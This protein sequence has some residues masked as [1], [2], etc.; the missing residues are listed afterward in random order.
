LTNYLENDD[1]V[2]STISRK[3]AVLPGDATRVLRACRSFATIDDHAA[4]L[5]VTAV[6]GTNNQIED[7]KGLLTGLVNMGLLVSRSCLTSKLKS[8]EMT[9]PP[10]IGALGIPTRDRTRVLGKALTEYIEEVRRWGRR[11]RFVIS[12]GSECSTTRNR[13]RM[14]LRALRKRYGVEIFY[15]GL[16]E[17]VRFAERLSRGKGLP[18]DVLAFAFLNTENCGACYGACRNTLLISKVGSLFMQV[19]DDTTPHVASPPQGRPNVA[20]S[21]QFDPTE[22]WFFH[23]MEQALGSA[24]FVDCNLLELHE[25]LLG[26]KVRDYL[27]SL[28]PGTELTLDHLSSSFVRKLGQA[29]GGIRVTTLGVLGDSGIGRAGAYLS[30]DGSSRERLTESEAKYRGVLCSRKVLRSATQITIGECTSCMGG[31]LGLDARTLLPPFPPAARA[32]EAV[33][34]TLLRMCFTADYSGFLPWALC[35]A[36]PE[37]RAFAREEV[38]RDA[39]WLGMNDILAVLVASCSLMSHCSDPTDRLKAVGK[40]LANFEAMP[41]N[42]FEEIVR[43]LLWRVRS[44]YLRELEERLERYASEPS[45][46]AADIRKSIQVL[47]SSL[48]SESFGIPRELVDHYGLEPARAEFKRLVSRFGQLLETWPAIVDAALELSLSGESLAQPV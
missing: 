31:N 44:R 13:N 14:L 2:Y 4:S 5:R 33:F 18:F 39:G 45:Y 9:A 36:P 48:A 47:H 42:D 30:L 17:K 23:S 12:D 35:H 40:Y 22:F 26:K 27:G 11:I 24:T 32:E 10:Q 41:L 3:A 37:K 16:E 19:D 46:W 29:G 25:Q 28:N 1:L 8:V 7:L 21:S 15:A 20:L 38:W 6:G 34:I 43:I